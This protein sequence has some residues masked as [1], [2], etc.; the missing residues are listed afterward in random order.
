MIRYL[1]QGGLMPAPQHEVLQIEEDGRFTMWRS[2]S[3]A[4]KPPSARIGRFAGTLRPEQAAAVSEAA[5]TV[6]LPGDDRPLP[7]PDSVVETLE[8]PSSSLRVGVHDRIDG[9]WAALRDLLRSLLGE[10]TAFPAAAIRLDIGDA[11]SVARLVHEGDESILLDLHD[12]ALGVFVWEDDSITDRWSMS[13]AAQTEITASPGWTIDLPLSH[14][15]EVKRGQ[16][17]EV[18]ATFAAF[19]DHERRLVAL[20]LRMDG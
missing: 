1:R 10:L 20:Q 8:L 15:F 2:V 5:R 11:R 3:I 6:P 16:Q 14:G 9:P 7:P 13:R 18:H 19:M 12:L 17:L 4:S